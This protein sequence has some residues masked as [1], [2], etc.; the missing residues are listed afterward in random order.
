MCACLSR[1]LSPFLSYRMMR[2]V[3][4]CVSSSK[5]S[6][7]SFS[8]CRNSADLKLSWTFGKRFA[9]GSF[10]CVFV[11][12]LRSFVRDKETNLRACG[13]RDAT[14]SSV[15]VCL[16]SHQCWTP[17]YLHRCLSARKPSLLNMS[18]VAN[19]FREGI[20]YYIT[21]KHF[22]FRQQQ[23]QVVCVCVLHIHFFTLPGRK[24]EGETLTKKEKRKACKAILPGATAM[25]ILAT[26]NLFSYLTRRHSGVF[27]SRIL[28]PQRFCGA[29]LLREGTQ[30]VSPL[31]HSTKKAKEKSF[32]VSRKPS[33]RR[34]CA[35]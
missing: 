2:S 7:T 14:Q 5:T 29:R 15:C 17:L 16:V 13:L 25:P 22:V 20:S 35:P 24:S 8:T 10:A 19:F 11:N 6:L 1:S 31:T 34:A 21:A 3:P 27:F 18:Q 26:C 4:L 12:P 30:H 32:F 28:F 9:L 23:P 33:C